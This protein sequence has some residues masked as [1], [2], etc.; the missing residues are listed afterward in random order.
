MRGQKQPLWSAKGPVFV[1]LL[2]LVA[3]I[4]GFGT[5]SVSAELSGAIITTGQIEVE[6]NRQVVQ[7]PDG[8]VVDKIHVNEGAQVKEGE[9][10][11]Q[12]DR[13]ELASEESLTE[14]QLFEVLARMG[15]LRAEAE[16]LEK[17]QF[18]RELVIAAR[19]DPIV[20]GLLQGQKKLFA[21]RYQAQKQE[22]AQLV[23]RLGKIDSQVAGISAQE[24]SLKLQLR[25]IGSELKN[26]KTL[27]Q[28]G[29]TQRSRVSSLRREQARLNGQLAEL[30]SLRASTE[31]QANEIK[32][33]LLRLT[34]R[35]RETSLARLRDVKAT[36]LGLKEKRLTLK[37][38]LSRLDI[39]APVSGIVYGMTIFAESAVIQPAA[40]LLYI[41]P[42]DRPLVISSRIPTTHIDQVHK[43]Q[44]VDI[45]LSAFDRSSTPRLRGQVIALSP[46]AFVDE[47]TRQNY[48]RAEIIFQDGE[49]EK[50]SAA[51]VLIPGMPVEAYFRTQVRTPIAYLTQ[52]LLEY[53][54]K[55]F[56]EG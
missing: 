6:R 3:L 36:A 26:Q 8:G 22:Q 45:A 51:K 23:E 56:R 38:R 37:K 29:L 20:A 48:Y 35:T 43:G 1:G 11:I 46:D 39:R 17:P 19:R 53:F 54:G 14:T 32:I 5:W 49:L 50:L 33:D 12:L 18:P 55:A 52:P 25:L 28:R 16:G 9:V 2:A 40:T 21:L 44:T 13:T 30:V 4:G 15:R 34:T 41:V 31:S 47:A 42:Q 10:L 7:H 24:R 27:L